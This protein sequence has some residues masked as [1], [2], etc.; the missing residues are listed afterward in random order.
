MMNPLITDIVRTVQSMKASGPVSAGHLAFLG[1]DDIREKLGEGRWERFNSSIHQLVEKIIGDICSPKDVHFKLPDDQYVF[2]FADSSEDAANIKAATIG[3]QISQS[4]FGKDGLDGVKILAVGRSADGLETVLSKTPAEIIAD[5]KERVD[6]QKSGS[7]EAP[8]D[9]IAREANDHTSGI[10]RE[11]R[12][13][14]LLQSLHSAREQPIRY[15]F[16]PFWHSAT[17]RV[18]TFQIRATRSS[19]LNDES[20]T[21]YAL[22]GPS[23]EVESIVQHD[24]DQ[25][26]EG[27]LALSTCIRHGNHV[28]VVISLHFE[29]VGS[30]FGRQKITEILKMVPPDMRSFMSILINA[31]PNGIPPTR[32]GDICSYFRPFCTNL[33]IDVERGHSLQEFKSQFIRFQS[34]GVHFIGLSADPD[35]GK[36]ELEELLRIGDLAHQFRLKCAVRH[37][38]TASDALELATG[39]FEYCSGRLFGGPFEH[40]PAPYNFTTGDLER[41]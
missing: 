34:V 11:S 9:A 10:D 7:M 21:G 38:E 22:L 39:G 31:V 30:S 24:I 26:E 25:V 15:E 8:E 32:L 33:S 23:P 13:A 3:T 29:T 12:R 40:L 14:K 16:I 41:A 35:G 37:V 28:H 5:V 18:A 27:L 17:R 2:I 36:T 20:L 4:L 6:Q 19:G 1:L